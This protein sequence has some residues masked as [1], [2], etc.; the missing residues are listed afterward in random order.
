MLLQIYCMFLR[1]CTV[2]ARQ[3]FLCVAASCRNLLTGCA[4]GGGDFWNPNLQPLIIKLKKSLEFLK[5]IFNICCIYDSNSIQNHLFVK[6]ELQQ[7]FLETEKHERYA[8]KKRGSYSTTS[9]ANKAVWYLKEMKSPPTPALLFLLFVHQCFRLHI[10]YR[11]YSCPCMWL[12]FMQCPSSQNW[13][14]AYLLFI[15]FA[16]PQR[17][18]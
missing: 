9:Q 2:W 10:F 7:I 12:S 16:T 13:F 8:K 5:C 14:I 6:K 3:V 17:C 1:D 15:I 11:V 18:M 4:G